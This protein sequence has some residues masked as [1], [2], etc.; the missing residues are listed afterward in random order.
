M[1]TMLTRLLRK[2]E[3]LCCIR[4]LQSFYAIYSD[5]FSRITG[6]DEQFCVNEEYKRMPSF[7]RNNSDYDEVEATF[8]SPKFHEKIVFV[9]YCCCCIYFCL[10]VYNVISKREL[11]MIFCKRCHN[12]SNRTL[13]LNISSIN[14]DI[15]LTFL[16]Y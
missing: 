4:C 1:K 11:V 2:E 12:F 3:L 6:E 16:T 14:S 13:L 7:G 9:F 5:L 10:I 8:G 15:A